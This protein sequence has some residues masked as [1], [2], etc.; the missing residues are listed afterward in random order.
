MSVMRWS[1]FFDMVD[2]MP[3]RYII[4]GDDVEV[5]IY[6]RAGDMCKL[7]AELSKSTE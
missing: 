7:I 6:V 5:C 3:E 2:A 1:D 4:S